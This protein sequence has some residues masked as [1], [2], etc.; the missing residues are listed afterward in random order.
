[1]LLLV[2]SLRSSFSYLCFNLE[3]LLCAFGIVFLPVVFL[4]VGGFIF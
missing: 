2:L 4:I 1:M 3:D